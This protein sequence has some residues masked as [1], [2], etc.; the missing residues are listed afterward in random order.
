MVITIARL[1]HTPHTLCVLVLCDVSPKSTFQTAV[2]DLFCSRRGSLSL[3]RFSLC[4]ICKQTSQ[5]PRRFCSE[6]NDLLTETRGGKTECEEPSVARSTGCLARTWYRPTSWTKLFKAHLQLHT[7][8]LHMLF[9]KQNI[10]SRISSWI[11][12]SHFVDC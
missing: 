8:S 6:A 10:F 11:G 5:S 2:F 1:V 12:T 9:S 3:H 7:Y 4:T